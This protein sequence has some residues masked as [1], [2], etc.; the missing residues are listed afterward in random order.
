V[1]DQ[2]GTFLSS[3]RLNEIKNEYCTAISKLHN[4]YFGS[5][6]ESYTGS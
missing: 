4:Y 3:R 2:F 1:E 6:T 5:E